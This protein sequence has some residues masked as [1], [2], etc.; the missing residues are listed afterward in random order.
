MLVTLA[1]CEL[2]HWALVGLLT[3]V[4]L[5][6]K[7]IVVVVVVGVVVDKEGFIDIYA[8]IMTDNLLT[9]EKVS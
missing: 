9:Y 5:L 7:K 3:L 1:V 6:K 8:T 2:G 4:G